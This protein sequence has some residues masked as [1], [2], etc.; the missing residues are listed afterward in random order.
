M[1]PQPGA[2]QQVAPQP[3]PQ[4]QEPAPPPPE[5]QQATVPPQ[6]DQNAASRAELQEVQEKLVLLDNR[7]QGIRGT[8]DNLQRAQAAKGYGLGSQYTGPAGLMES[9]LR[10]AGDALNAG[11]AAAARRFLEKAEPPIAA[12]EKL[13]NK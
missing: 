8:L 4:T 3:Q 10:G 2:A 7:A 12:L 6:P 5:P 9:Y 11:D 1:A 13:L